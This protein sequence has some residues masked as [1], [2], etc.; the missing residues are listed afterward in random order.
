MGKKTKVYKVDKA[1]YNL[2]Q[3]I[4]NYMKTLTICWCQMSL[5][6]MKVTNVF[7]INW[8]ITFALSYVSM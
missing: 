4:R 6:W 1:L 5:K 3:A 2:K 7:T 8:K